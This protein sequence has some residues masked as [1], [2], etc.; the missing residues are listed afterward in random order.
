LR[1]RKASARDDEE[2]EGQNMSPR[3]PNCWTDHRTA[4]SEFHPCDEHSP[5]AADKCREELAAL[6]KLDE[7]GI[8]VRNALRDRLAAAESALDA[9]IE[10][11]GAQVNEPTQLGTAVVSGGILEESLVDEWVC[12][13][14]GNLGSPTADSIQHAADCTYMQS[15]TALA[16]MKKARA[17]F[18]DGAGGSGK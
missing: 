6:K 8:H 9:G 2:S 14:C 13:H 11:L 17:L 10:A 12:H 15:L 4:V 7:M 5:G 18:T 16:T 3:C 1:H